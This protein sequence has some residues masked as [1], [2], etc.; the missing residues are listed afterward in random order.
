MER[1]LNKDKQ[2]SGKKRRGLLGVKSK[3]LFSYIII[4]CLAIGASAIGF[5]SYSQFEK[6]LSNITDLSVPKMTS[7]MSLAQQSGAFEVSLPLLSLANS[8]EDRTERYELL[9]QDLEKITASVNNLDQSASSNEVLSKLDGDLN[10]LNQLTLIKITTMD[11]IADAMQLLIGT[12]KTTSDE[13]LLLVDDIGFNLVLESED[14]TTETIETMDHLVNHALLE[15]M[16]VLNLKAESNALFLKFNIVDAAQDVK[17]VLHQ[18]K[19]AKEFVA[20]INRIRA[21]LSGE[22]YEKTHT[23]LDALIQIAESKDNIFDARL[24]ELD[25]YSGNTNSRALFNKAEKIQKNVNET[26]TTI[27]DNLYFTVATEAELASGNTAEKIPALMDGGVGLLKTLLEYRAESN[28]LLGLLSEAAQVSEPELLIPIEEQF[29]ATRTAIAEGYLTLDGVDGSESIIAH[30]DQMISLGEGDKSIPALKRRELATRSQMDKQLNNTRSTLSDLATYI[31][32]RVDISKQSVSQASNDSMVTIKVSKNFLGAFVLGS[33]V[34]TAL[35]YWLLVNRNILSRLMESIDALKQ[36]SD[37]NLKTT[38]KLKGNDEL[39][40]LA[41]TVEVFREKTLESQRLQKAEESARLKNA[42]QEKERQALEAERQKEQQEKY[43][44]ELEQAEREK[45][46]ADALRKDTDSL[47]TVVNAAAEGDL[48]HNISVKGEHPTGQLGEGLETLIQSFAKVMQQISKTSDI[49]AEGSKSIADGNASLSMRTSQQAASLEE[50]S[51]S[52]IHLTEKVD[53]NSQNAKRASKLASGALTKTKDVTTVV[54]DAVEAMNKINGS[55]EKISNIVGVI[56]EIA[57][58]TN[59][60]ALNASVEAARAGEQGRGFAVVASEV[61]NLAVRSSTAAQEIKDLIEQSVKEVGSG[62]TLVTASGETLKELEQSVV[63]VADVIGE[64]AENSG[65]QAMEIRSVKEAIGHID[66]VT[67]QNA[68]LVDNASQSSTN[69]AEESTN[70]RDQ[71][72]FFTIADEVSANNFSS[73]TKKV[74]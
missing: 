35:L 63:E 19:K 34:L 42:E 41:R 33:L 52:M 37:G 60:L 36:I 59:L 24:F 46:Q 7:A 4:S 65:H 47:L 70:L 9:Q 22:H 66:E 2:H 18:Q 54:G 27:V 20:K 10:V 38:V 25:T 6:S 1:Q 5:Y 15:L 13:L 68:M 72:Q 21:D 12:H 40:E 30:L 67:Q 16:A 69:M 56:D 3:L 14:V 55:S 50:T 26:L 28:L 62:V 57:F 31:M 11:Q 64:I 51:S 43:K 23:Y 32:N 39:T 48:T 73:P 17:V 71:I 58:Q 49:V 8:H 45:R 61:R 53:E 29:L 44:Q 74:A